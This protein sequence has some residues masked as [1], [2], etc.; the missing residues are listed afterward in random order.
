MRPK[1]ILSKKKRLNDR[2]Y[3][4][5]VKLLGVIAAICPASPRSATDMAM[6]AT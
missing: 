4:P 6:K 2:K 1:A 5:L 3:G